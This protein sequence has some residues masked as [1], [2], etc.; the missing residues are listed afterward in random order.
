MINER[1]I[2]FRVLIGKSIENRRD[3]NMVARCSSRLIFLSILFA[4]D[5]SHATATVSDAE[6]SDYFDFLSR[7]NHYSPL[8]HAGSHGTLGVGI[9]AGLVSYAGP[10]SYRLRREHW[11]QAGVDATGNDTNKGRVTMGQV[12]VHKGLPW[13]L[14]IGAGLARDP[15]TDSKFIAGYLQWTIYEAFARP[16]LA[17]RGQYSR[18]VG[19]ATT[20]AS[21]IE[22][23]VLA[24]YGFLR[25]FTVYGSYGLAR[26]DLRLH[27]GDTY[28]TSLSLSE[29]PEGEVRRVLARTNRSVG[30]Q[31]QLLPPFCNA[32]L[33]Y[34]QVGRDPAS[35]AAKVSFGM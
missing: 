35:F 8:E 25:L 11:R 6:L 27:Y 16:A 2:H 13:S 9:G 20:D 1:Y 33:E 28:G 26:H 24:S 12:H 7:V 10:D 3:K 19:M 5:M 31:Y 17:L 30:L 22:G 32:A 21:A 4:I 29:G 18:F 23:S 14:D 15:S 34:S